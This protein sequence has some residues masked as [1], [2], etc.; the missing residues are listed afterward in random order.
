MGGT[1]EE[2]VDVLVSIAINLMQP[3]LH[4]VEALGVRHI[5]HHL[6]NVCGTAINLQNLPTMRHLKLGPILDPSSALQIK[7]GVVNGLKTTST[8]ISA[9]DVL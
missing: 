9:L 1:Y 2:L 6:H 8:F 5:V 3:L 4:V 7:W